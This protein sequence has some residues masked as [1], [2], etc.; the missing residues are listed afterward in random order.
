MYIEKIEIQYFRSI[1]RETILDLK[2]LNIITGKNDV[3]KS[4]ILKALNLFFNNVTDAGVPFNFIDNFNLQRLEEVRKESIKGKQ[5]IQI[6][7][8]FCRGDRSEKTLPSR[9][10][11]TKKWLRNDSIPSIITDDLEKKL[12]SEN[13]RYNDRSKSSLTTY[14]NRMNYIY[15]P[16]IK[17]KETFRF[18]LTL[19]RETIYNDKLLYDEQLQTSMTAIAAR[20][21]DAA[22]ELNEEFEL[23]TGVK[24]RLTSPKNITELYH[25][26]GVETGVGDETISLDRRGDGIRIRYLPSILHYI[27]KNSSNNFIWG[28]EEPENSLEYTLALQMA[29]MFEETYCRS[30]MIFCTSHSPAFI[31]L[32]KSE[33]ATVFRCFREG[34]N[35]KIMRL[36][37][38]GSQLCMSEEL[39]YIQLQTEL[40]SEYKRKMEAL[41]HIIY[42]KELLQKELQQMTVPVLYTEGITDVQILQ[43]AWD[44]LYNDTRPFELKSCNVLSEKDGSAAGCNVLKNFLCTTQPDC[45]QIVIGLFDRDKEGIKAYGLSANFEE[46]ENKWKRHKNGRAY[47]L[48]LPIP[49]G[50]ESFAQYNN[51]CIEY[52][53]DKSDIDK[54]IEGKGLMITAIP[55]E[56]TFK[57]QSVV[58]N[59]PT[60]MHFH[61]VD[62]NTKRY[63]ADV[64][65]P[66]LPPTSFVHFKKLFEVVLDILSEH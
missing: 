46:V 66:S 35:T 52:F 7:V 15:I 31:G 33:T 27:S 18:V 36:D 59:I 47:A 21:T 14:L 2:S 49:D 11:V 45:S 62:K 40:F 58:S 16:A 28:F 60:E 12:T 50:K 53:F 20:V 56:T 54:R 23:A 29:K 6:K 3:G 38:A 37:Q 55:L 26:M 48:L 51:L 24:T 41:E 19:L 8:T 10:T 32:E 4:N 34:Q 42:K 13:K 22:K 30:S 17:D 57:G 1:Y 9:F 43:T 64:I 5:Y 39:G 65:V 61:E 63:F 44:K 25:T